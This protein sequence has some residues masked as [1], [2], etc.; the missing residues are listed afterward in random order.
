MKQLYLLVLCIF[1]IAATRIYG[2]GG[3]QD[4]ART[5][6]LR[7]DTTGTAESL[8]LQRKEQS[9][10]DSI[11]KQEL[12]SE[13]R[14]AAG[15][16]E[17][18]KQLQ[19]QLAVIVLNDSLRKADQIKRIEALKKNA[20]PYPVLLNNDTLFYLYTRIGSFGPGERAAAITQ[21]IDKLYREYTF[22]PDSLRLVPA[23]NGYDIFY[24][25]D[26]AVM[27]IS[28]LDALAEYIHRFS[29]PCVLCT[30]FDRDHQGKKSQQPEKLAQT[31]WFPGDHFRGLV[32]AYLFNQQSL[33]RRV[34]RLIIRKKGVYLKGLNVRRVRILTPDQQVQLALT[35]VRIGRVILI[36]L[37]VYIA[38][39]L[40]S[41]IFAAT[42]KF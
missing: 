22:Y 13:L 4:S 39:L 7:K 5:D 41:G 40:L 30:Y 32:P 12:K 15:N 8:L 36:V 38:L 1:L 18:T 23:E 33:F 31:H 16:T 6:S 24:N 10:I 17:R 34:A 29:C 27:S 37:C 14:Q 3:K 2:Q 20:H 9:L 35:V 11:A 42:E 28:Q 26:I 21:R 25:S 19:Q